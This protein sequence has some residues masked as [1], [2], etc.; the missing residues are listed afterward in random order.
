[1]RCPDKVSSGSGNTLESGT[2]FFEKCL[3]TTTYVDF[4]VRDACNAQ[5][6]SAAAQITPLYIRDVRANAIVNVIPIY[7]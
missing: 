2:S 7:Q 1:M 6:V 3:H 5:A 4:N